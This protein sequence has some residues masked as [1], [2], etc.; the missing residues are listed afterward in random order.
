MQ[1]S[2]YIW[3]DGRLT[4]WADARVHVLTHALHYG[5][6]V[7]EGTRAYETAAGPAVFR[8]DDHLIRLQ[9]SAKIIGLSLPY[10]LDELRAATLRTVAANGHRSCYI[11]H[12]VF[13]GDGEMGIA[14]RG[15]PTRVS[16]ASW[17]WEPMLG[18][19]VR[20]MTSSWRRNDP[21]VVPTSAKA[22]GPYLNSVLAKNEA[23][24]AGYD[25]AV[26]LN[27]HGY[28]SEC[29]GAN[30]F[31]VCRGVLTTPPPH[32]GALEGITQDTVERLAADLGIPTARR[33]L[34]RA[35][36]YTAEE[37]F[38]CGTAAGVVPVSSIDQ[39]ELQPGGPITAKLADAYA[40]TVSAQLPDGR[41][42]LTT[43]PPA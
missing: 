34:V 5:T 19:G 2:E 16:I 33:D 37:V 8:L 13:R 18:S 41:G 30:L 1:Q 22:T 43:V 32:A 21:N 7:L 11:R 35:D 26:L 42:W 12:L 24:D 17:E 20:L 14:A 3:M 6:A 29:T 28:V 10:T 4:P 9:D 39:R 31:A 38:V 23:L 36:L 25:E 40:A 15:C 27:A